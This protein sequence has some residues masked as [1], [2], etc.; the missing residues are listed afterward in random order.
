MLLSE[1]ITSFSLKI[2]HNL[3]LCICSWSKQKRSSQFGQWERA[4]LARVGPFLVRRCILVQLCVWHGRLSHASRRQRHDSGASSAWRREKHMW[5]MMHRKRVHVFRDIPEKLQKQS[6]CNAD[7]AHVHSFL[8]DRTSVTTFECASGC[9]NHVGP[10]PCIRWCKKPKIRFHGCLP[11]IQWKFANLLV[12]VAASA[13]TANEAKTADA[14]EKN[15]TSFSTEL[16]S[17]SQ[18]SP[19]LF[20]STQP[21]LSALLW[22]WFHHLCDLHCLACNTWNPL[23]VIICGRSC[24]SCSQHKPEPEQCDPIIRWLWIEPGRDTQMIGKLLLYVRLHTQLPKT[25][26]VWS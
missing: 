15:C 14:H 23:G 13:S 1:I 11:Q 7:I 17:G 20:L 19:H 3:P 21:P 18:Q 16:P 25:N 9:P 12:T 24:S 22:P 6:S 8:M 26:F 4:G 2:F 5:S 10:T